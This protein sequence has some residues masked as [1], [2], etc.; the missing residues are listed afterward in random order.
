VNDQRASGSRSPHER[1]VTAPGDSS[2]WR[3]TV[4]VL[5][6]AGVT[7]REVSHQDALS[8]FTILSSPDVARA[9]APAPQSPADLAARIES[10]VLDRRDG[11]GVWLS[12]L[13]DSGPIAGVFRVRELEPGFGSAE[14]DFALGHEQW[15]GGLFL[16][17]APLVIDFVFDV[18]GAGRLEA[19]TAVSNARGHGALR[20]LGAVQEAVLRQSVRA[21]GD[22]Y[23][24]QALLT[25]F[26]DDWRTRR[27][28]LRAIH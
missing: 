6:G 9:T 1:L 12:V 18:L 15:G 21:E 11:R 27:G 19:R 10:A 13:P 3:A 4:P 25:L 7:L 26:A 2:L 17:T 24:D 16:R 28:V 5:R 14:W 23:Q 20:K 8:L 22:A